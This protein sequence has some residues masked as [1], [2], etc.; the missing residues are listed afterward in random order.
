MLSIEVSVSATAA[1]MWAAWLL[2]WRN[3]GKAAG[4]EKAALQSGPNDYTGKHNQGDRT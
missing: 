2:I 3:E 1:V 4:K